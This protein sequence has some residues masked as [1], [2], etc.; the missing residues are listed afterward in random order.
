M[1]LERVAES[2][3]FFEMT[4]TEKVEHA[5]KFDPSN[6]EH[7]LFPPLEELTKIFEL[8]RHKDGTERFGG[9]REEANV[10]DSSNAEHQ[11][12]E[13][14]NITEVDANSG[15]I[16]IARASDAADAQLQPIH[17]PVDIPQS[18]SSPSEIHLTTAAEELDLQR[19]ALEGLSVRNE[20]EEVP[21]FVHSTG[22]IELSIIDLG[23]SME[24]SVLGPVAENNVLLQ[25]P[26]HMSGDGWIW[27]SSLAN[28]NTPCNVEISTLG[29][30]FVP[31]TVGYGLSTVVPENTNNVVPSTSTISANI[32]VHGEP[33]TRKP[34]TLRD[35]NVYDCETNNLYTSVVRESR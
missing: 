31:P 30:S 13:E 11:L 24:Y 4:D 26:T 9:R 33:L 25:T 16:T 35:Q 14:Q 15:S 10:P 22:S 5:S 32:Q 20:G 27:N 17:H 8:L 6:P 18:S 21:H 19:Y 34:I 29:A 3:A 28:Q 7:N 1:Y 23:P 12:S 2:E